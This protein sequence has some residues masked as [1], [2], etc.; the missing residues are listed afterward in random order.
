MI[1]AN[2][3]RLK[4]LGS[5]DWSLAWASPEEMSQNGYLY[6]GVH[7]MASRKA[8]LRRVKIPEKAAA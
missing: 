7:H 4:H 5:V 1:E 2:A 8:V 3:V 6:C